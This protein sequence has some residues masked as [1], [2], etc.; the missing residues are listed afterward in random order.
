MN[1]ADNYEMEFEDF[2]DQEEGIFLELDK[3]LSQYDTGRGGNVYISRDLL[4]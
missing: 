2:L 3:K 4:L 1:G